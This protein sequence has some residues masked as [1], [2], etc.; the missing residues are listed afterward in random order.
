MAEHE[1]WMAETL[2]ALGKG[3]E[4]MNAL[5]SQLVTRLTVKPAYGPLL[6]PQQVA[7]LLNI[8][9]RTVYDNAHKLGGFYPAGIMALRF[10]ED[11]LI[12]RLERSRNKA[13]PSTALKRP[14]KAHRGRPRKAGKDRV[15]FDTDPNRHGL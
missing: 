2:T 15:F 4:T 6:T 9:V 14:E 8:S 12:E 10:R 1:E 5:L 11:E 3:I 7:E 13:A